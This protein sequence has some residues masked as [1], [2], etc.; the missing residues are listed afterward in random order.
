MTERIFTDETRRAIYNDPSPNILLVGLPKSGK[1]S[2][3]QV[4]FHKASPHE[5]LYL[6]SNSTVH[7]SRIHNNQLLK[8]AIVDFPGG[9]PFDDASEQAVFAKA[10]AVIIVIDAQNEPYTNDVA[11]ATDVIRR[12]Y[13]VNRN[14]NFEV[15]IHKVDGDL[16]ALDDARTEGREAQQEG[17]KAFAELMPKGWAMSGPMSVRGSVEGHAATIMRFGRFPHR[18]AVLG[19]ENTAEEAEYLAGERAGWEAPAAPKTKP[20]GADAGN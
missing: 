12:A 18:N 16:F 19:R 9:F 1:S 2:I 7:I 6:Q 11:Y 8:C 20:T 15:F 10:A 5:T 3:N 13:M 14:I 17:M 4:V